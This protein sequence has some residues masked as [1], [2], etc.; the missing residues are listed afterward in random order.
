MWC[1]L[2]APEFFLGCLGAVYWKDSLPWLDAWSSP[3][4]EASLALWSPD[5]NKK[6]SAH[7]LP[8]EES[9]LS[10]RDR[11]PPCLSSLPVPRETLQP[12]TRE[13]MV[14]FL[15][16]CSP[17]FPGVAGLVHV[18]I[19]VQSRKRESLLIYTA[20]RARLPKWK[21]KPFVVNSYGQ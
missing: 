5:N 17:L 12:P 13:A 7:T 10:P 8:S 9:H 19:T 21:D 14:I 3:N 15:Y 2:P 11:C 1:R 20:S 18:L 16:E 6:N 4:R